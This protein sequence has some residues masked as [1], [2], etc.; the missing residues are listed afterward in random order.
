MEK[1]EAQDLTKAISNLVIAVKEQNKNLDKISQILRDNTE[2]I[3]ELKTRLG[4]VANLVSNGG[5]IVN[6]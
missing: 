1:K 4:S 5:T 6:P 3:K 2:A